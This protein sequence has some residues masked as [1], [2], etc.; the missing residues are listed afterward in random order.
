MD[1]VRRILVLLIAAIVATGC[2]ADEEAA[3]P[4][5]VSAT[6]T[7]AATPT[8]TSTPEPPQTAEPTPEATKA[9]KPGT[10][11]RLQESAF[12]QILFDG[13]GQAIYIFENDRRN[14]TVCYGQCAADWPP[15]FADG[16]PVAGKGIRS[17]L[18]GTI[19]RRGGRRQVTY[20]G[21][22]L[23]YYVDEGPGEVRCHNVNL[24]GG[25]WWVLGADG[26]RKP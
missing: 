21:Q 11:I 18:L 26:V 23:Y 9:P 5:Q 25:L 13:R 2:G 22:P 3:Q 12:G 1:V 4:A 6:E 14:E 7:P 17:R 8:A 24:N 20:A 19:K 10:T 16:K 15:V